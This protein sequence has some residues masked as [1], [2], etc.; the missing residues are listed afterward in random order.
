MP[1][2]ACRTTLAET[3]Q[4][5]IARDPTRENCHPEG[6]GARAWAAEAFFGSSLSEA[7]F[8]T[9]GPGASRGV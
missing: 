2:G 1:T 8:F 7:V 5:V 4:A 3:Q 9:F 6:E